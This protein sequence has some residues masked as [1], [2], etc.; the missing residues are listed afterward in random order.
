MDVS[1]NRGLLKHQPKKWFAKRETPKSR[2]EL[3]IRSGMV[4]AQTFEG[5]LQPFEL[6]G[7][8]GL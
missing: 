5:R 3:Q 2:V 4:P 1:Q 7:S 6:L 8:D